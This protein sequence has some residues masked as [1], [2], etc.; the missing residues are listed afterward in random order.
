MG[1]TGFDRGVG[2]ETAGRGCLDPV[3]K[4]QENNCQHRIRSSRLI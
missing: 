4:G 2:R 1:M 3:T